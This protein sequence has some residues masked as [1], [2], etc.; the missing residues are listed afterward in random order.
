MPFGFERPGYKTPSTQSKEALPKKVEQPTYEQQKE[1]SAIVRGKEA[2]EDDQSKIDLKKWETMAQKGF[3]NA[4]GELANQVDKIDKES[5]PQILDSLRKIISPD[6]TL[7]IKR[8]EL[9]YK[10]SLE[11]TVSLKKGDVDD[12]M[13]KRRA[14]KE[15][16]LQETRAAI[17]KM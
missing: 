15:Q 3:G 1:S 8:Q 6:E 12:Y 5:A 4:L 9:M 17:S 11:H 10:I 16:S 14:E 2:F 13:N 7:E